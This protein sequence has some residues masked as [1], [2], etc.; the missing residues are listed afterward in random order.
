MITAQY[1][2]TTLTYDPD[3]WTWSGDPERLV[4]YINLFSKWFFD[5]YSPAQGFPTDA[6]MV[7][8]SHILGEEFKVGDLPTPEFNEDAYY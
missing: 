5:E 6:L 4:S 2:G 3:T 1:H 8:L 7:H